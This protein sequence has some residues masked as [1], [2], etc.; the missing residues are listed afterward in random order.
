M[1]TTH[2]DTQIRSYIDVDKI[3]EMFF[4]IFMFLPVSVQITR[5]SRFVLGGIFQF[6]LSDL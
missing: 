6:Y 3:V 1:D 4:I 2:T 5:T